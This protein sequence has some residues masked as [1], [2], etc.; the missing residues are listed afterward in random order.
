MLRRRVLTDM[1]RPIP[2]VMQGENIQQNRNY[3]TNKLNKCV[4]I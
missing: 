3:R 1:N 4:F 2:E